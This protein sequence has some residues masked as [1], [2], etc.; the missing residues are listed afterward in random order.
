MVDYLAFGSGIRT[1]LVVSTGHSFFDLDAKVLSLVNLAPTQDLSRTVGTD[2][3]PLRFRADVYFT[4]L[5]A[6]REINWVGQTIKLGSAQLEIV[7]RTQRCAATNVNLATATR[8]QNPP[9]SLIDSYGHADLGI[10][11]RVVTGGNIQ[12]GNEI[13]VLI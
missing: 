5:E 13:G 8:D 12:P 2:L 6:W 11:A 4:G 7:K 9:K 3:D 10:Y 1:H